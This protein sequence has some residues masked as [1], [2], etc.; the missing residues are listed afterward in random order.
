MDRNTEDAYGVIDTIE[1]PRSSWERNFN[2][3]T[4][5]NAGYLI[6]FYINMDIIPGTTIKNS[7][8]IICRMST[9]MFPTMDNLYLD[10][11]YFKCSKFWYWEHWRAMMGENELGAWA[12]EIEYTEPKITTT[13]ERPSTVNDMMTYIGVPMGIANLKYSKIAVNAYID[14]WNQWFRDQNLQAPIIIDKTD[15]NLTV[16]GTINTGCGLLPVQKYHDYFTSCLPEPQKGNAVTTPLGGTAPVITGSAA[17]DSKPQYP[18]NWY[19]IEHSSN[20]TG[21]QEIQLNATGSRAGM[22]SDAG[23]FRQNSNAI[24]PQNLIADLTQAT[25]ATINALRLAFATQR[26]LEKDARFGT[27]YREILRGHF[28]VTASDES[29]LTPE[30]LGGKRIPIN[31]ETVLQNSSTD[32]ESPLGQTGAFSVTS[33]FNE[34]FTKSFT[35]DDIL[36]GLLCVRADHTYQQGLPRQFTRERRLD[37]YWPSLAHIGN[38]PVYNYEIYA[39]GTEVDNEVFGY[40]E[41]WQEYMYHNNRISGELLSTYTQ[42]LDAWHY[43]DDYDS[44]PVLSDE[45]IKEPQKFIDRT[46][47]V[48]S[49]TSH[50]FIADILVKQH[51]SAPIPLN[52]VPGLIDHF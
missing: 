7:T 12:Q 42:S 33:D 43:G 39:Q 40:K 21:A 24:A 34:D 23:G 19:D 11:Y 30:Y 16:D 45:W 50:Q 52:R 47:A 31:I 48:Q 41:A 5:F 17:N 4:S 18:L 15:A 37:R 36:I 13:V 46:L 14:I 35:K 25:A 8:S 38:Q 28:G 29:L 22:W 3:K 6:P 1:S 44:L 32:A 20:F 9:P 49:N 10:L 51:V 27:R 2:H 26:I